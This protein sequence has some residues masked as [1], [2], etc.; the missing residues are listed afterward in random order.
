MLDSYQI[1]R[2]STQNENQF[3]SSAA[4]IRHATM[5]RYFKINHLSE[6]VR[7]KEGLKMGFWGIDALS[8]QMPIG[9]VIPY[10]DWKM[11]FYEAI[12]HPF[13]YLGN[14]IGIAY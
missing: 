9:L 4:L 5:F 11:R 13:A 7:Y 12:G 14:R 8:F 10:L 6:V 3:V 2:E 1:L